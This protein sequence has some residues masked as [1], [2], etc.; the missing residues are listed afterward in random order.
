MRR[1]LIGSLITIITSS[2]KRQTVPFGLLGRLGRLVRWCFGFA[3]VVLGA[4]SVDVIPYTIVCL[5]FSRSGVGYKL[6]LLTDSN[7]IERYF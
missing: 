3:A 5:V 1:F 4:T 2:S 6:I 7:G